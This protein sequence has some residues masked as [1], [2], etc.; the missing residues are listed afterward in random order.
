MNTNWQSFF[1]SR[2]GTELGMMIARNTGPRTAKSVIDMVSRLAS[3]NQD[4][5]LVRSA[6][7]NQAIVRGLPQDSPELDQ[8]VRRVIKNAGWAYYYAYNRIARGPEHI[9]QAVTFAPEFQTRLQETL[10]AGRGAVLVGAHVGNVDLAFQA[11]GNMLENVQ[12]ITVGAPPEGYQ[13]QNQIRAQT[14]ID[15]TP[16]DADAV[17]AAFRRL[18]EGG[19]VGTASDR[20]LPDANPKRYVRFFGHLAPLPT[21]HVRLAVRTNARVHMIQVTPEDKGRISISLSP[22]I[23]LERSNG[24]SKDALVN[25]ERILKYTEE[26]IRANPDWW[27]M[28][29]PVWPQLLPS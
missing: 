12:A 11:A 27:L 19:I 1:I 5:P 20:P 8:I 18:Q 10:S 3:H 26:Q 14:G 4:S 28:F 25:T 7:L 23:P 13:S 22:A 9:H 21:G 29:F 2:R 15:I 17:K 16:G 6:R 24:R